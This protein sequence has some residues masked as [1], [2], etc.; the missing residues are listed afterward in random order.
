MLTTN[1]KFPTTVCSVLLGKICV[2]SVTMAGNTN[3]DSLRNVI[4]S[5]I[6]PDIIGIAGF[7]FV[8]PD[9]QRSYLLG[10]PVH[11]RNEAVT[12]FTGSSV[13]IE[14]V[15][16]K[17][18]KRLNKRLRNNDVCRI[19]KGRD[20]LKSWVVA[21]D[22]GRS[23]GRVSAAGGASLHA[24]R[25]LIC[26]ACWLLIGHKWQFVSVRN[27]VEAIVDV[28]V[29]GDVM[30]SQHTR[31]SGLVLRIRSMDDKGVRW[32]INNAMNACLN[33]TWVSINITK[34][35]KRSCLKRICVVGGGQ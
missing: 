7:Y 1:A 17:I 16:L 21:W 33:L 28:G 19:V 25:E 35:K 13:Y 23:V 14:R 31:N 29:E 18:Y 24:V 27:G 30:L 26:D 32:R 15:P 3:L 4:T 12:M 11:P 8:L 9:T 22:D 10:V 6:H 5:A 20:L 2:G 34:R